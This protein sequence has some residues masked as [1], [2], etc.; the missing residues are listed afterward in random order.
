MD[1]RSMHLQVRDKVILFDRQNHLLCFNPNRPDNHL[2]WFQ[3]HSSWN[4]FDFSA[5]IIKNLV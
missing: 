3:R 2:R 5:M 4:S 1:I